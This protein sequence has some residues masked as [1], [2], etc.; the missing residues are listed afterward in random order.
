ML[1]LLLH[2]RAGRE[3]VKIAGGMTGLVMGNKGV[4]G[5]KNAG[6]DFQ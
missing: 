2:S 1:R 5:K 3:K 4:W 6:A